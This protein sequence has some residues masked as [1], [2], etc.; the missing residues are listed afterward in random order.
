MA[1]WCVE[2][3]DTNVPRKDDDKNI[4]LVA[5][6]KTSNSRHFRLAASTNHAII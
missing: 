2:P 4:E 1:P 3:A 6:S 5:P